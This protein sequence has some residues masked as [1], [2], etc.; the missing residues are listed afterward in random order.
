L[1]RNILIGAFLALTLIACSKKTNVVKL[2]SGLEYSDNKVGTGQAAKIGDLITFHFEGWIVKDK[3]DYFKDWSKDT[4]KTDNLI[5]DSREGGRGPIKLVLGVDRFIKG[6]DSAIVGMKAGGKRTIIIPS[7]LAYGKEG[8]GPIP[9]NSDLKIVVDLLAC[10]EVTQPTMWDVDSTKTKTTKTGL[11]YNIIEPGSGPN[12]KAGQMV[13]VDYNGWL[14]NGK[15]FD[16]SFR[17]DQPLTFVVGKHMVI[18]GWDEGLQLLKKGAKARLIIPPAL[19]YGDRDM[20]V[21]PPNST[22]IF[23]IQVD[24]VK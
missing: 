13:T 19:A 4:T 10:K 18:A 21:I 9:P 16:S 12:I 2:K 24:S 22:L 8:F 3:A 15:L 20:G 1:V 11:K 6:I 17:R 7:D 14:T 23:D 5:G